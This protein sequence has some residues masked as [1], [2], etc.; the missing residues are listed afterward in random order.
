MNKFK[1]NINIIIVFVLLFLILST[2]IFLIINR[3][4]EPSEQYLNKAVNRSTNYLWGEPV[5]EMFPEINNPSYVSQNEANFFL[6]DSD[7][8][9]VI[10]TKNKNYIYPTAVLSYHHIVND[11][12]D[13]KPVTITFCLLTNSAAIYSRKVDDKILNFGVL[14]PLYLGNLVMYDKESDSYWLQLS[15]EAIKGKYTGKRLMQILPVY[16]TTWAKVRETDNLFILPPQQQKEFYTKFYNKYLNGDMGLNALEQGKGKLDKRLTAYDLGL[17]IVVRNEA[18]FYPLETIRKNNV[19]ND[20]AGGW[21]LLIYY[22]NKEDTYKIFRR[23][24]DGRILKFSNLDGGFKD[25][26][27]NSVFDGNGIGVSGNLLNKQLSFPDS[28]QSYWF[29][30]AAFYPQTTIYPN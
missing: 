24:L 18:R 12:I 20:Q 15:G 3:R 13:N 1:K 26:Q 28:I 30:W 14:G 8:V 2:V 11:V 5:K 19:I 10:K 27:T 21:S 22:D 23:N 9:F 6:K 16:Q 17:G 25:L 4:S 29:S 7:L